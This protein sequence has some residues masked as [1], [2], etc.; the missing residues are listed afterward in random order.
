MKARAV[1]ST[2]AAIA[3]G[4]LFGWLAASCRPSPILRADSASPGAETKAR[5]AV[6]SSPQEKPESCPNGPQIG[7]L[8][9]IDR[10][11]REGMIFTDYYAEQSCTAGR[12]KA[13]YNDDDTVQPRWGRVGKQTIEDTGALT[14]KRMETIDDETSDAAVDFI[15]R[16]R[17]AHELVAGRGHD[18]L[19]EREEHQ[20]GGSIP[21]AVCDPLART[22]LRGSG[23]RRSAL[24]RR[25]RS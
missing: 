10:I 1:S 5:P 2:A 7:L 15:K 16:Q 17:A 11:A 20:L 22:S 9:A 13:S 8:M 23:R 21:G 3:I 24:T 25:S 4:A 19:P 6:A 14:K 12:C 18:P